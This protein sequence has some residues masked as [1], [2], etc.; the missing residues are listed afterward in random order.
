V[1]ALLGLHGKDGT[2]TRYSVTLPIVLSCLAYE[3]VVLPVRLASIDMR[4]C[5][6]VLTERQCNVSRCLS[7]SDAFGLNSDSRNVKRAN[8]SSRNLA[9]FRYEGCPESIRPF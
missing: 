5:V 3:C 8:Y 9:R 6:L 4:A 1:N 2:R 7:L